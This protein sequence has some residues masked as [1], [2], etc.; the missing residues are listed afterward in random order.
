MREGNVTRAA[1]RL[2]LSQPAMSNALARLRRAAGDDLF[3]RSAGGVKATARAQLMAPAVD[4]A[5]ALIE[6]AL[7]SPDFNSATYTGAFRVAITDYA[8]EVLMPEALARFRDQAPGGQLRLLPFQSETCIDQLQRGEVD[9]AIGGFARLP[10]SVSGADLLQ[11]RAI[12]LRPRATKQLKHDSRLRRLS[13]EEYCAGRHIIVSPHGEGA[14]YMDE[15]LAALGITRQVVASA[16]QFLLAAR[17]AAAGDLTMTAP[18]SFARRAAAELRLSIFELP[19]ELG[20]IRLV[21]RILWSASEPSPP[22][23]WLRGVFESAAQEVSG[24]EV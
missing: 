4:Q 7:T 12:I 1:R 15:R 22:R 21:T 24:A 17:L 18:L 23:A 6:K 11:D 16:P 20:P 19:E 10:P 2:A 14:G 9:L 5:L 8:A 3:T 13:L